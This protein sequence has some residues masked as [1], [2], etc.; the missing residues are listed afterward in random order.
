MSVTMGDTNRTTD[1]DEAITERRP[2]TLG[3]VSTIVMFGH[4]SWLGWTWVVATLA[5]VVV[6]FCVSRWGDVDQ[7]L[8][9]S[10]AAGWQRWVVFGTGV[11]TTTVYLRM[12]VR[13]GVTRSLLSSAS[14]VAMTI[15]AVVAGLWIT[16][17]YA[18]EKLVYDSNGWAQTLN[19]GG[20]LEWSDLWRCAFEATV[21]LGAYF[22]SGWLVGA[23]Y[24]RYRAVGGTLLLL[25][26]LVPAALTELFL[27]KD[28]GGVDIDTLAGWF[29]RPPLAV[30]VVCGA[31]VVAAG[32]VVARRVTRAIPIR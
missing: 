26:A 18:I 9:Q 3:S 7:S 20:P 13:N 10:V 27:S 25:P 8:W 31:T 2:P 22:V 1:A 17:G 11:T 21:A 4:L 15:I 23:G 14:T 6:V 12:L 29:D 32:A 19:E 5:E 30:S 24:Y 28:F 16:A